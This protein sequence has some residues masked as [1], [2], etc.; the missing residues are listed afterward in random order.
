MFAHGNS[1]RVTSKSQ[2]D[3]YSNKGFGAAR[4]KMEKD[5]YPVKVYSEKLV[6]A[7]KLILSMTLFSLL[8]KSSLA[9]ETPVIPL[10]FLIH[11]ERIEYVHSFLF[12]SNK[13]IVIITD[14][15]KA[16]TNA[17][18]K[19]WSDIPLFRCWIH[20]W[21]NMMHTFHEIKNFPPY[22]DKNIDTDINKM[23]SW[24]LLKFG[25]KLLTN[26]QSE[27]LNTIMKRLMNW[28]RLSI[29]HMANSL[30]MIDGFFLM[31]IRRGK[32]GRRHIVGSCG[33]IY[34][35]A[36]VKAGVRNMTCT[37][38]PSALCSHILAAMYSIDCEMA[39][40]KKGN[41]TVTQR[42]P[43]TR[44]RYHRSGL[45]K[46]S[47]LEKQLGNPVLKVSNQQKRTNPVIHTLE[48]PDSSEIEENLANKRKL[49]EV[50]GSTGKMPLSLS[51]LVPSDGKRSEN[52]SDVEL[53]VAIAESL[54]MQPVICSP[55]VDVDTMPNFPL[56]PSQNTTYI[57]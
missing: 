18:S 41:I 42:K 14:E 49:R 51:P 15:E 24:F 29:D 21:Q 55:Y 30:R 35:V 47:R 56:N 45:K 5:K 36:L 44:Q 8:I 31:K 16:I 53:E 10:M 33:D 43:G 7:L 52:A 37:C 17:V 22:Y 32:L 9:S 25:I 38:V 2:Q 19:T 54:F 50:N 20:A 4:L 13:K 40:K 28:K 46:P 26:N 23:E 48:D 6:E 57:Y 1:Q 34:V 12:Y 3:I 39:T 11:M 27:S